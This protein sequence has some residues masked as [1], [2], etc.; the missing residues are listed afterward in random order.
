MDSMSKEGHVET[1]R[2]MAESAVSEA[3]RIAGL[4]EAAGVVYT[5][6]AA[7][8]LLV[9]AIANFRQ[10]GVTL[11][12]FEA[13]V[14]MFCDCTGRRGGRVTLSDTDI[15]VA[16]K[17]EMPRIVGALEAAKVEPCA[18]V[19][20]GMFLTVVCWAKASGLSFPEFVATAAALW[21]RSPDSV[22]K[23]DA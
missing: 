21:R 8:G 17:R 16:T 11:P 6:E 3:N 10:N 20:V 13:Y 22:P 12:E 15:V 18:D 14:H 9:L 4:I 1:L 7:L 23:A 5:K 19:A 2:E